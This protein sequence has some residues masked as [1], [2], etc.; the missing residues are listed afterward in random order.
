LEIKFP[1][2]TS[3]AEGEIW[4]Q[5]ARKKKAGRHWFDNVTLTNDDGLKILLQ[6]LSAIQR[7]VVVTYNF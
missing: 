3:P 1:G 7:G 5:F 4:H 6:D 2:C